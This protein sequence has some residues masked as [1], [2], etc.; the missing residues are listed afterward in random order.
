MTIFWSQVYRTTY[1]A[2]QYEYEGLVSSAE[3]EKLRRYT[4]LSGL[5][6]GAQEEARGMDPAELVA[7]L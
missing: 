2:G 6:P 5:Y 7:V 4:I 3:H 1:T